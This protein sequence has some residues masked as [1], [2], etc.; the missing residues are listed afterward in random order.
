LDFHGR[1]GGTSSGPE[2]GSE[3]FYAQ[4]LWRLAFALLPLV[5]LALL[6]EDVLDAFDVGVA[7]VVIAL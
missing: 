5:G 7:T 3:E 6:A 2:T 1:Q 4:G